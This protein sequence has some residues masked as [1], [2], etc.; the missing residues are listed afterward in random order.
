MQVPSPLHDALRQGSLVVCAGPGV[1][2]AASLPSTA[3]IILA[4]RDKAN[5]GEPEPDDEV[6]RAL[7]SG[8]YGRAFTGLKRTLGARYQQIVADVLSGSFVV[9]P[10]LAALAGLSPQLRAVFT[11]SLVSQLYTR[12][13]EGTWSSHDEPRAVLAQLSHMVFH[14]RGTV[15]R[16]DSWILTRD[17]ERRALRSDSAHGELF[18]AAYR[19]QRLLVVGFDVDGPALRGVLQLLPATEPH[20]A[21]E[22]FIA[23]GTPCTADRRREL[24]ELGFEVIVGEPEA[25][26]RALG[27]QATD[28]AKPDLPEGCP[29]PGLEAFGEAY[30]RAFFGRHVEVSQAAARLGDQGGGDARRWLAIEG[31][32]GVGKSSFVFAGIIPA[33]RKG[34][35]PGTSRRWVVAS[36]RPGAQP[37]HNLVAAL[38]EALVE[39]G[40]LAG[41]HE[42]L[43][44]EALA[45]PSALADAVAS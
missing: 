28:A 14:L 2:A 26:L 13:F 20:G 29:Y 16:R 40:G 23:L 17:E 41:S 7:E 44:A 42:A 15:G 11:T 4:L 6:A 27:G 19:S 12:A 21:P 31:P 3:E 1:D 8:E 38:D 37:L 24:A 34:F 45:Q 22:H 9:P 39:Q 32:S 43:V 36:T 10:M 25:L 33:L 18:G 35:A 30:E 5:E